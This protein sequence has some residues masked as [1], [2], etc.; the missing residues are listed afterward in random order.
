MKIARDIY[1]CQVEV[2]TINSDAGMSDLL[3]VLRIDGK[4]SG[5]VLLMYVATV[6]HESA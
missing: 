5:I 4:N 3:L 1:Y 2:V 6:A